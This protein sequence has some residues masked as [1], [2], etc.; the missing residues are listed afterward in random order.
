[1][2]GA[3]AAN[4][5]YHQHNFQQQQQQQYPQQVQMSPPVATM[6]MQ[7]GYG[8]QPSIPVQPAARVGAGGV[9]YNISQL[10]NPVDVN[11]FQQN[12]QSKTINIDAFAAMKR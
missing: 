7:M 12:P 10:M 5:M 8:Q 1:M 9:N 2:G 11:G 4:G 6:G 3:P